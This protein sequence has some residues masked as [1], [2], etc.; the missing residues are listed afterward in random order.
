MENWPP[1]QEN[2]LRMWRQMVAQHGAEQNHTPEEWKE[3]YEDFVRC[4]M[5]PAEPFVAVQNVS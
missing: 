4:M 5:S 2:I 3:A 1:S